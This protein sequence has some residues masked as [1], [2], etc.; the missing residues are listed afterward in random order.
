MILQLTVKRCKKRVCK[1][2]ERIIK[3]MWQNITNSR[4]SGVFL[5]VLGC[6]FR[7]LHL[8]YHLSHIF[9]HFCFR[10]FFFR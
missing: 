5:A 6:E 4:F 10:L 3:Q 1:Y 9:S 7:A 2:V 8:L